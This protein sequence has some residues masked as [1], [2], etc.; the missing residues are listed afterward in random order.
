MPGQF[1]ANRHT[2]HA[3]A[4]AGTARER[5]FDFADDDPGSGCM[6]SRQLYFSLPG[7]GYR[8][9]TLQR[10]ARRQAHAK[11]AAEI[12]AEQAYRAAVAEM[13]ATLQGANI[14]AARAALRSRVGTIPVFEDAGKLYGRIGLDPTPLFRSRTPQAFGGLVA[15]SCHGLR[16]DASASKGERPRV[17]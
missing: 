11:L 14:E 5:Q 1:V 4:C 15:E 8:F 9:G 3:K 6:P 16:R 7:R 10:G 2:S 17:R 13:S 12:P